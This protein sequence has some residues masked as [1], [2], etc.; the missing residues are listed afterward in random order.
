MN[1]AGEHCSLEQHTFTEAVIVKASMDVVGWWGVA[2]YLRRTVLESYNHHLST[3]SFADPL[4]LSMQRK[5]SFQGN[6]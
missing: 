6:G 4:T 5:P 2:E 1:G 3:I